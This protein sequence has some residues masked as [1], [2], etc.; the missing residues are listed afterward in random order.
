MNRAQ[1]KPPLFLQCGLVAFLF[2]S[3]TPG[4]SVQYLAWL[5]PW[6]VALG[7]GATLVYYLTSGVFLF[8]VYT[9]WSHGF[10]WYFANAWSVD[11]PWPGW[12]LYLE[13]LCW[14]SVVWITAV[15]VNAVYRR[16]LPVA[17]AASSA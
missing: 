13:L 3:L 12:M 5:V 6:V 15:Y 17:G 7:A 11:A 9:F 10:P 16:S 14:V 8:V 4:F 2:M 1:T